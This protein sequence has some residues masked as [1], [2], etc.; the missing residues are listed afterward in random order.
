[1]STK[2]FRITRFNGILFM[3]N[4]GE[5]KSCSTTSM[6]AW[7]LVIVGA[8]NWLLVGVFQWDLVAWIFGKIM[9]IGRIVYIL[10]GIS[11]IYLIIEACAKCKGGSCD[12]CADG[13]CDE[14]G[15]SDETPAAGMDHAS[16][17]DDAEEEE[18]QA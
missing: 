18:P 12:K 16:M 10:V 17:M 7:V 11:G 4:K 8:L 15:S 13:K 5:C 3:K 6:I 2:L 1:V 14:H 9:I